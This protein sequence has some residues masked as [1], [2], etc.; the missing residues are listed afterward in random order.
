[1][2]TNPD[3]IWSVLR[4]THTIVPT[5]LA[6]SDATRYFQLFEID[7]FKANVNHATELSLGG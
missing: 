4:Q 7:F 3:H 6:D 2:D 1:M 5:N